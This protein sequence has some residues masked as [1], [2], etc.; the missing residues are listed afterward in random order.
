MLFTGLG[1]QASVAL[2]PVAWL[3]LFIKLSAAPVKYIDTAYVSRL[4]QEPLCYIPSEHGLLPCVVRNHRI[5]T[6]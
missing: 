5:T 3:C 2:F 6:A 4:L 1:K